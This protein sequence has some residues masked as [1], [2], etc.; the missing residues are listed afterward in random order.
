MSN[1]LHYN[2]KK[3]WTV[4]SDIYA[5][6]LILLATTGLF[7]IKGKNG[8]KGRGAWLTGLGIIVPVVYLLLYYWK[9]F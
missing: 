2:P 8:I 6:S 7:I 4:I 1:Y 3:W 9:V 5:I